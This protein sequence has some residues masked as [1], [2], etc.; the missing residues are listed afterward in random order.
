MKTR[1][2]LVRYGFYVLLCMVA[3]SYGQMMDPGMGRQEG[4]RPFHPYGRDLFSY[5]AY[6]FADSTDR[7]QTQVE[8][9]VALVNDVL[10]FVK[11]SDHWYRARYELNIIFYNKNHDVVTFQSARD[12]VSVKEFTATNSRHNPIRHKFV[13]TLA[14]DEY[15]YKIELQ[16]LEEPKNMDRLIPLKV[17]DFSKPTLQISDVVLTDRM[18]CSSS[19]LRH[20]TANLRDTFAGETSDVGVYFEVYS[21]P[22]PDSISVHYALFAANGEDIGK[23][24]YR[25]A[26]TDRPA[27]CISLKPMIKKPGEYRLVI[28]VQSGKVQARAERK[29]FMQWGQILLQSGNIDVAIEQLALI[30]PGASVN[31]MRS[32]SAHEREKLFDLFWLNRDPTPGTERNELREEFFSRIDFANHN[33]SEM[34]TNQEGW[35]T[36]RGRVLVRNGAP[37][38]VDRQAAEIGMPAVEIWVYTRLAKKYFFVDRQGNGEYRLVKVE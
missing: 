17:V 2:P 20:F 26:A 34:V 23:K 35:R 3:M 6:E 12:T 11:M 37:D 16:D 5:R 29:F 19:Q 28:T 15:Q 33:F 31:K 10:N 8:F 24:S 32:A 18:Y 9:H 27:Q 22:S 38:N 14:P 25:I 30:A 1:L 13:F 21:V 7:H 36:D 4:G